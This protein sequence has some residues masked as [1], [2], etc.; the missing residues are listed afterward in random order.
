MSLPEN[1][2]VVDP[3]CGRHIDSAHS[4]GRSLSGRRAYYFCSFACKQWF[5][6]DPERAVSRADHTPAEATKH[7]RFGE[8]PGR[9]F[10]GRRHSHR[11]ERLIV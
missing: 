10:D 3:V 9:R 6:R 11:E 8:T 1:A 2:F 5:D 7:D 4:I